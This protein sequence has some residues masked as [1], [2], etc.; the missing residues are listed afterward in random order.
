[1]VIRKHFQV[2]SK[3]TKRV[4][5]AS[6]TSVA[7]AAQVIGFVKAVTIW[8]QIDI[9]FTLTVSQRAKLLIWMFDRFAEHEL[10]LL[11]IPKLIKNTLAVLF[12]ERTDQGEIPTGPILFKH[13]PRFLENRVHR[14]T[15]RRRKCVTI[16]WSLKEAKALCAEVPKSFI[17]EAYQ[18]HQETLSM[19]TRTDPVIL[20]ALDKFIEP[21]LDEV[22]S[23]Y[24][25]TTVVAPIKACYESKRSE[26]GKR[27]ALSGQFKTN[28]VPYWQ[29]P[30]DDRTPRCEPVSV[31]LS[32]KPGTGKS[33]FMETLASF[34][35]KRLKIKNNRDIVY[36]RT[37]GTKHWDGYHGQPIVVVDDFLQIDDPQE[38]IEPLEEFITLNSSCRRILPMADLTDKGMEFTSSL[39]L[40]STNRSFAHM[41]HAFS[42]QLFSIEAAW[43]RVFRWVEF[44]A[45]DAPPL[46]PRY[47]LDA[48]MATHQVLDD[49]SILV[50]PSVKDLWKQ[51]SVE[52]DRKSL[53]QDLHHT[54]F[55]TLSQPIGVTK[56]RQMGYY[57]YE[58]PDEG[59][60]LSTVRVSAVIEP[61]K[62]RLITAGPSSSHCLK[63]LQMAMLD[64]LQKWKCFRGTKSPE[65]IGD[66]LSQ[67]TDKPG[68]WLSGD[69]SSAT[70][71][72]H[73]DFSQRVISK[74]ADRFEDDP[75]LADWIRYEGGAHMIEYP[76]ESGLKPIHQTNGQLMGSLLSFPI[77]CMANAFTVCYAGGYQLKSV[78]A[79]FNG[80]DVAAKLPLH[81]IEK[82]RNT[83]P[84]IGMSLSLGKNYI[85]DD[86]VSINSQVYFQDE[87]EMIK[88]ATGKFTAFKADESCVTALLERRTDLTIDEIVVSTGL[89]WACTPKSV[90]V[91]TE[92]GGLNP[93]ESAGL[94]TTTLDFKVYTKMLR[95]NRPK[96]F[97]GK[98]WTV[99]KF[100][101]SKH[102]RLY[103]R[104][105]TDLSDVSVTHPWEG[106]KKIKK[107]VKHVT[108]RRSQ[109]E[110]CHVI[111]EEYEGRNLQ[112]TYDRLCYGAPLDTIDHASKSVDTSI[113]K[114]FPKGK[115]VGLE[116][117]P[118]CG[119]EDTKAHCA[120]SPRLAAITE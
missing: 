110:I 76:R 33:L 98:L 67:L 1:M 4:H 39:I 108:L 99:P 97:N 95:S 32:G 87:S 50:N 70:D 90:Q 59:S 77:L 35:G 46:G 68:I 44:S 54:K 45:P 100:L 27:S 65:S 92:Y 89:T 120:L 29:R 12:A 81:V 21:W 6:D 86:W 106:V 2:L 80:D 18:K 49:R 66:F 116:S 62:V 118:L 36:H 69:Y 28:V 24:N 111:L 13:F 105:L 40:Y 43:R 15:R 56:D 52:L 57:I 20:D 94:P 41:S 14:R 16:F 83:A 63:P 101:V 53:Y 37:V 79:L 58:S 115:F 17:I 91:S 102:F 30:P 26:G 73:M 117:R 114:W 96:R 103:E 5:H 22:V 38:L 61:L 3:V 10:D 104:Q 119:V 47:F 11:K 84:Q 25:D 19:V 74:L 88:G 51:L 23:R 75:V 85:N 93:R 8:S 64:G 60:E 78:P 34:V 9:K 42:N 113:E 48:R 55:A 107:P 72:L 7:Y 71:G 109:L 82:W 31:I 112:R